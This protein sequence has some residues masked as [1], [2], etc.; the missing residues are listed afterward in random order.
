MHLHF[1][2]TIYI[3]LKLKYLYWNNLYIENTYMYLNSKLIQS[4]CVFYHRRS[5]SKVAA[6]WEGKR[7]GEGDNSKKWGGLVVKYV[8]TRHESGQELAM[9]E[10]F[11]ISWNWHQ[12]KFF[13]GKMMSSLIKIKPLTCSRLLICRAWEVRPL[14]RNISVNE[15]KWEVRFKWYWKYL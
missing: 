13:I 12:T 1:S 2:T 8:L 6:S 10:T 4:F 9:R 7:R 3:K 5:I 14:T 15:S 11:P